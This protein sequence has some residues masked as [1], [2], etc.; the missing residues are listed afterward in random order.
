MMH[1]QLSKGAPHALQSPE[2]DMAQL[3]LTPLKDLGANDAPP[4]VQ[5][6]FTPF[7]EP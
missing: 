1:P 7:T 3:G 6:S 2:E 5:L 4:I